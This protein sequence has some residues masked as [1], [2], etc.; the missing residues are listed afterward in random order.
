MRAL[1]RY[2]DTIEDDPEQLQAVEE[3][4][5][6]LADL[7]RKYGDTV[8][9]ILAYAERARS[10]LEAVERQDQILAELDARREKLRAEAGALAGDAQRLAGRPLPSSSRRPSRRSWRT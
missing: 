3:R 1:R 7:K 2:L 5:L 9:E 10:R 4:L 6:A 8:E